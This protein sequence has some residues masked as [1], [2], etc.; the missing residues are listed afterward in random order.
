MKTEKVKLYT[1]KYNKTI[2]EVKSLTGLKQGDKLYIPVKTPQWA[3]YRNDWFESPAAAA[4]QEAKEVREDQ[5]GLVKEQENAK[6]LL[7]AL[8]AVK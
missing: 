6:K 4:K 2:P 3:Y 7:A 5:A 1:I 8:A